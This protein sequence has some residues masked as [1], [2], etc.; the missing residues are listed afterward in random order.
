[1]RTGRTDDDDDDDDVTIGDDGAIVSV[2]A[3][4]T[5]I[6][7]M[8]L[9]CGPRAAGQLVYILSESDQ[10][11]AVYNHVASQSALANTNRKP[12]ARTVHPQTIARQR[13]RTHAHT[14]HSTHNVDAVVALP[15]STDR[16]TVRPTADAL[17]LLALTDCLTPVCPRVRAR[18]R[19][20][21][22]RCGAW[23]RVG[24]ERLPEPRFSGGL[25]KPT[26]HRREIERERD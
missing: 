17:S 10:V 8:R 7:Q 21:R 25:T 4:L 26:D 22:R 2:R 13:V 3:D 20:R 23:A 9:R 18:L 1:M 15:E 24:E 11:S 14:L 16:P 12:V 6:L 5:V 19:R